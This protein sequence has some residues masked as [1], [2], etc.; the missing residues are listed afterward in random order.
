MGNK[1]R[2][3]KNGLTEQQLF[4]RL[5]K[6]A[7]VYF[8]MENVLSDKYVS[9][10]FFF[11]VMECI[12]SLDCFE[13]KNFYDICSV[14]VIIDDIN[15][16]IRALLQ[17]NENYKDID[18]DEKIKASENIIRKFLSR[19]LDDSISIGIIAHVI[20]NIHKWLYE[21]VYINKILFDEEK[22]SK[23]IDEDIYRTM[24][25]GVNQ[26]YNIIG[27]YIFVAKEKPKNF[28]IKNV[29]IY[30]NKLIYDYTGNKIVTETDLSIYNNQGSI[31]DVLYGFLSRC[32]NDAYRNYL[33]IMNKIADALDLDDCN[34]GKWIIED[35]SLIDMPFLMVKTDEDGTINIAYKD[36]K[37]AE[38]VKSWN[39]EKLYAIPNEG[40]CIYF[41]DKESY[42]DNV[43]IRFEKDEYIF[44]IVFSEY[45]FEADK[46]GKRVGRFFL[47]DFKL[48]EM[49]KDFECFN[50]LSELSC[51]KSIFSLSKKSTKLYDPKKREE[52]I[53]I[54]FNL[55]FILCL[56]VVYNKLECEE[57][58]VTNIPNGNLG[59]KRFIKRYLN[60]NTI[61]L[62]VDKDGKDKIDSSDVELSD[63]FIIPNGYT[64]G[65]KYIHVIKQNVQ[66][67][68]DY[69]YVFDT[70]QEQ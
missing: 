32:N 63:K 60:Y 67:F 45:W 16:T 26:A 39:Y 14:K 5:I 64:I 62:T 3:K 41:N 36:E 55:F 33:L 6:Y 27:N 1:V 24:V 38:E 65:E 9:K 40:C 51:N 54:S 17:Y 42:I 12:E 30:D 23:D 15:N 49:L 58:Y 4:Y 68:M 19:E 59:D 50:N 21:E 29:C 37:L 11:E 69:R 18:T 57:C 28:Y 8:L 10:D 48:K 52:S 66:K 31:W 2:K 56:Y 20:S 34:K 25:V 44:D 47:D 61:T 53:A 46:D 35:S 70:I 7:D 13:S 43:T 22:N